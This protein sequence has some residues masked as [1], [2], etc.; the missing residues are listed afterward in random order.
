MYLRGRGQFGGMLFFSPPSPLTAINLIA[1]LLGTFEIKMA[2]HNSNH[3]I[4]AILRNN[5][6]L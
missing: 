1:Y 6:G 4:C 5:R 3:L 2:A